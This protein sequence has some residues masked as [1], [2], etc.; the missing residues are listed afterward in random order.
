MIL[1]QNPPKD[2]K[3]FIE[4][5]PLRGLGESLAD[6]QKLLAD[7]TKALARLRELTEGKPG[8]PAGNQN[9]KT[10]TDNVSNCSDM[11]PAKPKRKAVQG[12]SRAYTV[13]RLEKD[14][15][16]LFERVVAKAK[17]AQLA[18]VKTE[19][20]KLK[21]EQAKLVNEQV[22]AKLQ[23]YQSEVDKLEAQKK[24]IEEIVDR[25]KAYLNSLDSEVKRL[26]VHQTTIKICREFLSRD[27]EYR[28]GADSACRVDHDHALPEHG[29]W[30][31]TPLPTATAQHHQPTSPLSPNVGA[32][33][34]SQGDESDS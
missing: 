19:L 4:A 3:E 20:E 6:I 11:F 9:A 29:A 28:D 31:S 16:D 1:T 2:F 32:P 5:P 10:I 21:K 13:A 25:K 17:A 12:N 33:S 14:R 15:P 30:A 7:D 34:A 26:E 8:A 27:S 23:G 22:K 18:T 24:T